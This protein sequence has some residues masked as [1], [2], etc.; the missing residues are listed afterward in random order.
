VVVDET[1]VV[2]VTFGEACFV[3]NMISR[4]FGVANLK[5]REINEKYYQSAQ[6]CA[7]P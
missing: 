4:G 5:L 7:L 1:G 2:G 6:I 3:T